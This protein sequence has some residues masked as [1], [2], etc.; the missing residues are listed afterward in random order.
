MC[1]QTNC[2][3]FEST[4]LTLEFSRSRV[5]RTVGVLASLLQAAFWLTAT[6]GVQAV[7]KAAWKSGTK[8]WENV[9]EMAENELGR[10][11]GRPGMPFTWT[12]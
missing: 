7:A 3:S 12:S 1:I 5:S 10:L 6:N 2:W 11:E 4:V 8:V 9:W